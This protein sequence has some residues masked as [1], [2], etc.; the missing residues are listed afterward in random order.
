ML[1]S[2]FF[3]RLGST[4]DHS[5]SVM[6]NFTFSGSDEHRFRLAGGS[7]P[8]EGRVEVF[9]STHG[10][11]APM[12]AVDWNFEKAEWICEGLRYRPTTSTAT[13]DYDGS[14]G[15]IALCFL[16]DR[17]LEYSLCQILSVD[18]QDRCNQTI[19]VVCSGTEPGEVLFGTSLCSSSHSPILKKNNNNNTSQTIKNSLV[20]EVEF[21]IKSC[22]LGTKQIDTN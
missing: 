4:D 2:M 7:T 11:W 16:V 15:P 9:I 18:Q 13:M 10:D 19:N 12:C 22:F 5:I 17:F 6:T 1:P 8:Y 21:S 14:S 3:L 20:F